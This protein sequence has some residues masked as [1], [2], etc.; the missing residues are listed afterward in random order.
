LHLF[1]WIYLYKNKR[2]ANKKKTEQKKSIYTDLFGLVFIDE[3]L[4][5]LFVPI[6]ERCWKAKRASAA[7]FAV[8]KY[9]EYQN[10]VCEFVVVV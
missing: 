7:A 5:V 6:N 3:S 2:H 10:G 8:G 9:G 4:G 1:Q